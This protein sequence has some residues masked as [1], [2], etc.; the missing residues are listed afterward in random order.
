MLPLQVWLEPN[1]E[2]NERIRNEYK[3]NE[4][5][6]SAYALY[7]IFLAEPR[8]PAGPGS[9]IIDKRWLPE[10]WSP[11]RMLQTVQKPFLYDH[12]W[13][14]PPRIS[15]SAFE[16]QFEWDIQPDCAYY[17]S[18]QAFPPHF[19]NWVKGFAPI[20][21]NRAFAPYLTIKFGMDR[22][23]ET[24]VLN[25]LAVTSAIALYNRWYLK[26]RARQSINKNTNWSKKQQSQIRHYSILFLASK[27][28]LWYT[29][30]KT[31]ENWTGCNMF[32]VD[33]GTCIFGGAKTVDLLLTH[34]NDI[35]FWGLTVHGKSCKADV[36]IIR[37]N[38]KSRG[39]G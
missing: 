36:D 12:L 37:Y 39:P 33:V 19:H 13:R 28:E 32:I 14:N 22:L 25:E 6:H 38:Q 8:I 15:S 21:Q 23:S 20:V 35:H 3:C 29:V 7:D 26:R 2:R 31:Y 18:L 9:L 34:L 24:A 16:K 11:V 5:E 17:V 1:G 30:P 4:A 10:R 27:W